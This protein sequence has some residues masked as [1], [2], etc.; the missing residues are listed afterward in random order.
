MSMIILMWV[1][2][3]WVF[4][5]WT[6]QHTFS[7]LGLA[8]ATCILGWKVNVS[9]KWKGNSLWWIGY[10][11][12]HFPTSSFSVFSIK[13]WFILAMHCHNVITTFDRIYWRKKLTKVVLVVSHSYMWCWLVS[14]AS[15]LATWS[16][17][18]RTCT[19]YGIK[20]LMLLIFPRPV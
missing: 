8:S 19:G 18:H 20:S 3:F 5:V 7:G 13:L 9:G 17:K 1:T 15:C 11:L 12:H 14:L 10:A 4:S 2:L 6:L 16:G